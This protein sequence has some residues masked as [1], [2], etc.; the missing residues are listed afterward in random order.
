M[1]WLGLLLG[2]LLGQGLTFVLLALF[3]SN[4]EDG[5]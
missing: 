5:R 1:F 4:D 2:F 3:S